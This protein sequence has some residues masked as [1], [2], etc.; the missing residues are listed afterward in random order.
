MPSRDAIPLHRRRQAA[1]IDY[2]AP[3]SDNVDP[4]KGTATLLLVGTGIRNDT[5]GHCYEDWFTYDSGELYLQ[6]P[7]A[8]ECRKDTDGPCG[9]C[10][11]EA[12]PYYPKT[13]AGGGRLIHVGNYYYDYSSK[14]RRYMGLRDRCEQYFGLAPSGESAV[15]GYSMFRA[16]GN[17]GASTGTINRWVREMCTAA[18]ISKQEREVRLRKELEPNTE[19]D[20]DGN[21]VIKRTVPEM[22]S[23][24]GK[25]SQGRPIPDVFAH[26]LRACY[27][28]QLCRT[29]D[30]NYSKIKEKTGHKNEETL[31]R[32]V[33][34]ASS[35]LDP[36]DD[37]KMF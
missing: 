15:G 23:D 29:A 28:T 11:D 30:P 7:A 36:E 22:I 17:K 37:A 18:G 4:T 24:N 9:S 8:D 13:P 21:E 3:P 27:C 5:C 10:D 20:E 12:K 33:G 2:L 26:D 35:E 6:V 1:L 32:Y 19:E 25:D 31:Y 34:F 14:E 16:N